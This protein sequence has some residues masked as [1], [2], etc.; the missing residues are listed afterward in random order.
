[1]LLI[2]RSKMLADLVIKEGLQ[3]RDST[4]SCPV[5][6]P[7]TKTL[8]SL[9]SKHC[10]D[11]PLRVADRVVAVD[12]S[13]PLLVQASEDVR[14]VIREEPD[15]F[16]DWDCLR[17]RLTIR[18]IIHLK[19]L[20]PLAVEHSGSHLSD[21]RGGHCSPMG[22]AVCLQSHFSNLGLLSRFSA[23]KDPP[24]QVEDKKKKCGPCRR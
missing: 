20:Q 2:Y 7:G 12:N 23:L 1:M 10:Q 18:G 9:L 17:C 22:V 13:L 24:G 21:S 11:E 5:C 3:E 15:H 16:I 19:F 4:A 8:S 6:T 14:D